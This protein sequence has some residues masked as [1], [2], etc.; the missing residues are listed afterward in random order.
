M[1]V[2]RLSKVIVLFLSLTTA[3]SELLR[4]HTLNITKP[5]HASKYLIILRV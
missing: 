1:S 4:K 3:K 5:I 2:C